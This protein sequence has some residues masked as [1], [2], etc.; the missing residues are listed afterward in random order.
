MQRRTHLHH[1]SHSRRGRSRRPPGGWGTLRPSISLFKL[2]RRASKIF[3][4]SPTAFHATFATPYPNISEAQRAH[5]ALRSSCRIM[6]YGHSRGAAHWRGAANA[7]AHSIV[8][9]IVRKRRSA[10]KSIPV[11]MSVE[12]IRR[13]RMSRVATII[14]ASKPPNRPSPISNRVHPLSRDAST[15]AQAACR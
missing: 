15:A 7:T 1:P 3:M 10:E 5:A 4:A 8:F 12:L 2:Q 6:I 14:R 11:M 9:P 13:H